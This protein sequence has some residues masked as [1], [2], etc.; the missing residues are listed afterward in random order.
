MTSLTIII[1]AYNVSKKIERCLT[2]VQRQT[3]TDFDCIVID[4]ASSDGTHNIIEKF[5][6]KDSRFRLIRLSENR[7][8]AHARNVGLKNAIGKY[9]GWVDADDFVAEDH[10]QQ[11]LESAI[12]NNSD[13]VLCDVAVIQGSN[14][15]FSYNA[16]ESVKNKLS[17]S[18]E[19][20]DAFMYAICEDDHCKSW[21]FNKLIKRT[22]YN[23]LRFDEELNCLEDFNLMIEIARKIK[24]ISLVEKAT[25]MYEL[26][27]NSLTRSSNL[28][29]KFD[30][31][32]VVKKRYK[33]VGYNRIASQF[34]L[35]SFI[36]LSSYIVLLCKRA[37]REDVIFDAKSRL[38]VKG[39]MW[40]IVSSRGIGFRDKIKYVVISTNLLKMY[41]WCHDHFLAKGSK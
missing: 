41:F 13:L 6:S 33:E 1:P 29:K 8:V 20:L 37:S 35:R 31:L 19:I 14:I 3:V 24:K 26:T 2:S 17:N 18:V 16:C 34:V 25:Y 15:V 5:C 21:M 36:S 28:S 11:L 10:F 9:I 30:W 38:L 23:G 39:L 22:V 32:A 40:D 7:G 12:K 4:D 27:E